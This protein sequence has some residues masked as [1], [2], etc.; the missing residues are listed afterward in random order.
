MGTKRIKHRPAVALVEVMIAT[1]V[2]VV[3]VLGSLSYEY[4]ASRNA[5]VARAQIAATRT[6]QLLL[7]DWMSTGGS[8]DYDPAALGL[9]FSAAGDIPSGFS[10]PDGMGSPLNNGVYAITVDEIP[11][12]AMLTRQDVDYDPVARIT[13]RQLGVIVEFGAPSG[14]ESP[15]WVEH[16]QPIVLTTYVRADASGG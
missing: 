1:A 10:Q 13:L 16:V 14:Q 12:L 2:L 3:A 11:M 6:A 4:H 8:E 9:D 5:Q 7:E 15:D